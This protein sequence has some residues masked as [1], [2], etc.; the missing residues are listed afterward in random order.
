MTVFGWNVGMDST[1]N[2]LYS[3]CCN[4]CCTVTNCENRLLPQTENNA[5][6]YL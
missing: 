4:A 3:A 1:D 6:A 5:P 2:T